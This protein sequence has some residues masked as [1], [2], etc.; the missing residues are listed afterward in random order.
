MQSPVQVH[1][2]G[3][4]V[5]MTVPDFADP[6]S[7]SAWL[8]PRDPGGGATSGAEGDARLAGAGCVN[9]GTSTLAPGSTGWSET[10]DVRKLSVDA[11]NRFAPGGTYRLLLISGE[12]GAGHTWSADVPPFNIA[13]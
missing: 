6:A 3:I 12:A 1:R 5:T 8:C 2:E 11:G 10:I 7:T 13:P 4:L 9:F